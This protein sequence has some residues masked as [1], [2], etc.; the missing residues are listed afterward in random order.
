M[1]QISGERLFIAMQMF[2]FGVILMLLTDGQKILVLREKRGLI[3]HC[4]FSW[5]RNLNYLGEIMLYSSFV[6]INRQ[7]RMLFIYGFVW[8][9]YF[10]M[11]MLCKD[12]SNS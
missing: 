11:R 8:T 5:S 12:Y 4:M 10:T 1:E 3:T 9:F 7:Y 2:F 6:V